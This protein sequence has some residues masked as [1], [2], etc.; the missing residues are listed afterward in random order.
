[1]DTVQSEDK[2]R[3]A[4]YLGF[5][6]LIP[7][8]G[9]AIGAHFAA[10][11]ITLALLAQTQLIYGA[12]IASF[13]GAVHWGLAMA[14]PELPAK[15]FLLSVLP[16][17]AGWAIVGMF[18]GPATLLVAFGLFIILFGWLYL[19]DRDAVREGR[20][21]QWYGALRGPLTGLVIL[22]FVIS[23]AAVL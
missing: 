8:Y 1:M 10:D 19:H 15:T 9:A 14:I 22:A 13:L 5:A 17:L 18:S 20:A 3:V 16:G 21:P 11:P 7:F 23:I 4:R 6:G 2:Q 12:V